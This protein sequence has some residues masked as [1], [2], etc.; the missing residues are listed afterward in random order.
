MTKWYKNVLVNR[1]LFLEHLM[2]G[3]VINYKGYPAIIVC[4]HSI[5]I[6]SEFIKRDDDL[7][8]SHQFN[9]MCLTTRKLI[10]ISGS[11]CLGRE[12]LELS[13]LRLLNK[14]NDANKKLDECTILRNETVKQLGLRV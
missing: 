9:A 14:Y 12:I 6:P 8:F 5:N 11:T 2:P 7:I 4:S 1:G 13:H 10:Y 3:D